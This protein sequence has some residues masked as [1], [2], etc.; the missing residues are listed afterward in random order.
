MYVILKSNEDPVKKTGISSSK[1]YFKKLVSRRRLHEQR[2]KDFSNFSYF[3]TFN[4][5]VLIYRIL[6]ITFIW[7]SLFFISFINYIIND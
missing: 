4:L 5:K 2:K 1:K 3:F 6:I 7:S